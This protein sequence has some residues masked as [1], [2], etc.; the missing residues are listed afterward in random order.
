M[1][2]FIR[3]MWEEEREGMNTQPSGG[4]NGLSKDMEMITGGF[5]HQQGVLRP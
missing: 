5:G 4:V 1:C 2:V 3:R